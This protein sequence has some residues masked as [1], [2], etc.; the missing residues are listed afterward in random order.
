ME[1]DV[2]ESRSREELDLDVVADKKWRFDLE[3]DLSIGP[4]HDV[5]ARFVGSGAIRRVHH[6]RQ[7]TVVHCK[8]LKYQKSIF[9]SL[10]GGSFIYYSIQGN[11]VITN[12]TGPYIFVQNSLA[13]ILTVI[14]VTEFVWNL[15]IW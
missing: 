1:A 4:L 6:E 7:E 15:Q 13:F 11:L 8:N 14:V 10:I 12:I 2:V 3:S 9:I 5:A